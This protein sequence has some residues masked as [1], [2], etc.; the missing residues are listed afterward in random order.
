[1]TAREGRAP[2]RQAA[3]GSAAAVAAMCAKDLGR[4]SITALWNMHQWAPLSTMPGSHKCI[5]RE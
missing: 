3:Q 1:M 2:S 5:Q 4:V